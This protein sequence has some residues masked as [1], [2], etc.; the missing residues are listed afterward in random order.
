MCYD[1]NK[2]SDIKMIKEG[3]EEELKKINS[4]RKIDLSNEI[5]LSILQKYYCKN[6]KVINYNIDLYH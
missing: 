2:F 4:I 6:M 3:D 5:Q 1:I